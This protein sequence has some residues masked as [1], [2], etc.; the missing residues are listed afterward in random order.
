MKR[1]GDHRKRA[2]QPLAWQ[3]SKAAAVR[4]ARCMHDRIDG[5]KAF[6]RGMD[7][8]GSRS[9]RREVAAAPFDFRAGARAL[10]SYRLQSLKPRCVAP[11]PM[12]HQALIGA[13]QAARGRSTY[14]GTT[15]GDDRN[16]HASCPLMSLD[17]GTICPA[18]T[19]AN[20]GEPGALQRA[21]SG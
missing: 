8:L 14:A 20:D 4:K 16:S 15:A 12:Q 9:R 10:R 21:D 13:G 17:K 5:A 1:G 7:K 6:A 2:L 11:L 19:I 3:I 18:P